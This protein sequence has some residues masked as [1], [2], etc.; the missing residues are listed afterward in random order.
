MNF[1]H[2][3]LHFNTNFLGVRC[4][5]TVD[6]FRCGPCPDG[7]VGD[8]QRCRPPGCETNPCY[9]GAYNTISIDAI[10]YDYHCYQEISAAL[11]EILSCMNDTSFTFLKIV[12][13][14]ERYGQQIQET[15]EVTTES[16]NDFF[17]RN[18][19]RRQVS[20]HG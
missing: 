8:G 5:D 2:K 3:L 20:G 4:Q 12:K 15:N 18:F 13:Y 16:V 6:G 17:Y 7:Y 10:L 1:S 9:Q 11:K 19:F 14:F